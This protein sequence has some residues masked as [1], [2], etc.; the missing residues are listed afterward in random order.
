MGGFAGSKWRAASKALEVFYWPGA[1]RLSTTSGKEEPN[2]KGILV[3]IGLSGAFF[4][5]ALALFAIPRIRRT[6]YDLFY[7]I[8][9]P[10]A[11]LFVVLG[12]IHDYSIQ[13]FIIP[14]L[15]TYFLDRTHRLTMTGFLNSLWSFTKTASYQRVNAHMRV[16]SDDLI[17]VDLIDTRDILTS[18]AAYGTQFLYLRVPALGLN[19]HPFSLAAL[20]PSFVIRCNGDWTRRLH[21]LAVKQAMQA[22]GLASRDNAL[23]NSE[24]I[25]IEEL[26]KVTTKIVCEIDGVY[27]NSSPPWRS[28][29]HVLFIGGGVGVT[30]WLAVMGQYVELSKVH[31]SMD[32]SMRLVWIGRNFDDLQALGPYLPRKN[33]TVYL[34][35]LAKRSFRPEDITSEESP[36]ASR[37]TIES[38]QH[39]VRIEPSKP[40]ITAVT[41]ILSLFLCQ[42]LFYY[43]MGDGSYYATLAN[44]AVSQSRY[45]WTKVLVAIACFS[46]IAITAIFTQWISRACPCFADR[47]MAFFDNGTSFTPMAQLSFSEQRFPQFSNLK[48]KLERPDMVS[49]IDHAIS[50]LQSSHL[51]VSL[52]KKGLF[53]AVCGPR[54]LVQSCI[55]AVNDCQKRSAVPIGL[56]VENTEW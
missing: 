1:T 21:D 20:C 51:S 30:P 8:H 24:H 36:S 12:A 7:L 31:D 9:L 49:L 34:T 35:R 10:S 13:L 43:V 28:F 18:E 52:M 53:V 37:I 54:G 26:S 33:T 3:F 38:N 17:G 11:A 2:T 47:N 23:L 39:F 22:L 15:V 4:A 42:F 40:W 55:D 14:G 25:S 19:S 45:F 48:V 44:S 6:R 46:A 41:G 27:G 56:H 32:Q 29:S 50:D 5:I 16:M